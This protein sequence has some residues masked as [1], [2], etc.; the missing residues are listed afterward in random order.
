MVAMAL[1]KRPKA[2]LAR[3]GGFVHLL[4]RRYQDYGAAVRTAIRRKRRRR[5]DIDTGPTAQ[6]TAA[7]AHWATVEQNKLHDPQHKIPG[8]AHISALKNAQWDRLRGPNGQVTWRLSELLHSLAI[9]KAEAEVEVK[10]PIPGWYWKA[11]LKYHPEIRKMNAR[12]HLVAKTLASIGDSH[13]IAAR[14]AGPH[15]AGIPTMVTFSKYRGKGLD[16]D[17]VWP[18]TTYTRGREKWLP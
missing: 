4:A 3:W 8:S 1:L 7:A 17:V 6:G 12:G 15:A 9:H 2:A 18:V 16:K 14:L 10:R 11:L 13:D 5:V